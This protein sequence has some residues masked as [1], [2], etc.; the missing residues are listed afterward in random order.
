MSSLC[1][2]SLSL[3]DWKVT[4]AP[5]S[6]AKIYNNHAAGTSWRNSK[7]VRERKNTN[8]SSVRPSLRGTMKRDTPKCRSSK[9]ITAILLLRV[10]LNEN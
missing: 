8:A 6:I 1:K 5:V 9:L 3:K 7:I 2:E 10:H 4:T